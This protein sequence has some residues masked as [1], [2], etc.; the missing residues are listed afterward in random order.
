[1]PIT[2][3]ALEANY[4]F[5]NKV[6]EAVK[7]IF[8]RSINHLNSTT[9][10][11]LSLQDELSIFSLPSNGMVAPQN[12]TLNPWSPTFQGIEAVSSHSVP[13]NNGA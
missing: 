1:M 2:M 10:F 9:N 5:L 7:Q 6:S 12:A 4:R 3:Q 8:Y 11:N 13:D